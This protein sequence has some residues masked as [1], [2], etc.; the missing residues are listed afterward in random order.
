MNDIAR[1]LYWNVTSEN[2]KA[3]YVVDSLT[4][5]CGLM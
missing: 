4:E 3:D 2:E 5:I 1:I